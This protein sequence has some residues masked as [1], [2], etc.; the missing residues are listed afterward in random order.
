MWSILSTL[1]EN[2][3]NQAPLP[4]RGRRKM[5]WNKLSTSTKKRYIGKMA[6]KYKSYDR[7]TILRMCASMLTN[8]KEH[9][10][11]YVVTKAI[12]DDKVGPSSAALLKDPPKPPPKLTPTESAALLFDAG[13]SKFQYTTVQQSISQK[14]MPSYPLVLK[15]KKVC[16]PDADAVDITDVHA[17]IS[18]QALL[19]VTAKRLLPLT[20]EFMAA[21][22]VPGLSNNFNLVCSWGMD[23]STGFSS[24]KMGFQDKDRG[25]MTDKSLLT[26]GLI[27]LCIQKSDGTV[28]WRN[29]GS[30]SG[31]AVRPIKLSFQGESKDVVISE[32]NRVEQ[33]I[34]KLEDF[35]FELLEHVTCKMKFV[36]HFTLLD[37]KVLACVLG[38]GGRA[39]PLCGQGPSKFNNPANIHNGIFPS[40]N[41]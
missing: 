24:M 31:R 26:V 35:C 37:G 32:K 15:A 14:V 41:L 23:G 7:E 38:T 28:V 25:P 17:T 1:N 8:I 18:L 33:E 22:V 2:A 29:L 13:L 36:L 4:K 27:P 11:S 19:N 39:C 21:H 30:R 10:L 6:G 5:D 3:E 9:G 40:Q 16:R 34:S 20:E 12:D